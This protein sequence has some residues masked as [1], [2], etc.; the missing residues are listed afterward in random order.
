MTEAA[1]SSPC[2][3]TAIVVTYNRKA[4]LVQCIEALLKQT[5]PC[6][7]LVV[8]NASTDN[9]REAIE[10]YIESGTIEYF[11]M[12][13][14]IGGAGGFNFGLK[15][16]ANEGFKYLWAMDDDCLPTPD[17]LEQLLSFAK[18][19]PDFGFL[20]SK[21]LWTDGSICRMNEPKLLEG[22]FNDDKPRRC[23]QASFVSFFT[24]TSTLEKHGLPISDFFIWGDDVEY[25]RRI[26]AIDPSWYVPASVVVHHTASNTGSDISKDSLERLGRYR[27]A[28]RNEVYIAREEGFS[29]RMYQLAKI[30]YH[31]GR[32]LFLS[33]DHKGERIRMIW[34]SSKEG[35]S[36]SPKREEFHAPGH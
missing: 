36:F 24:Q 20:S 34:S 26:S 29:R 12:E 8:D 5:V 11:R 31:T 35:L 13:K 19:H 16:A 7:I 18:E 14:N 25:T 6:R 15:T 22:S 23:R 28:Y 2:S 32:V 4:L 21:V 30:L 9:T 10:S 17:A 27:F 33:P 3:S 1:S